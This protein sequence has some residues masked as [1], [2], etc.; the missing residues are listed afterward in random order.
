[1]LIFM[2]TFRSLL[3][4]KHSGIN[5]QD[6]FIYSFL[7]GTIIWNTLVSHLSNFCQIVMCTGITYGSNITISKLEQYYIEAMVCE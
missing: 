5:R 7:F 1:M 4:N 6:L 2:R 3:R